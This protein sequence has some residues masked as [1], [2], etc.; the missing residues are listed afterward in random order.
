MKL[1]KEQIKSIKNGNTLE[2][3][4]EQENQFLI[5]FNSKWQTFCLEKNAKIIKSVNSIK[6]IL[7][8]LEAENATI[9]N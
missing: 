2:L 6:P 1:T 3:T 8:K 7:D 9:I 4:S 5:W